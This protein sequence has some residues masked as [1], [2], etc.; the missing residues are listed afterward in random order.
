[1]PPRYASRVPNTRTNAEDSRGRGPA[2]DVPEASDPP[3]PPHQSR[4][5]HPLYTCTS[6]SPKVPPQDQESC[7]PPPTPKKKLPPQPTP[8]PAFFFF[9][10]HE[11][12][13]T[14]TTGGVP[15]PC[16]HSTPRSRSI[17][18]R[19][20]GRIPDAE[21]G[22][23]NSECGA[24]S[25]PFCDVDLLCRPRSCPRGQLFSALRHAPLLDV[26]AYET[27]EDDCGARL[28]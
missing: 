7:C 21:R 20:T 1:M 19:G 2:I 11:R 23:Q 13:S 5:C 6:H 16:T 4:R 22:E 12:S 18:R 9:L 27:Q 15:G 24:T 3:T 25:T 14:A 28:R 8:P 17:H 26:L 10:N